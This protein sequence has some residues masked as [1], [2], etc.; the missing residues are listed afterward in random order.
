MSSILGLHVSHDSSACVVVDGKVVSAVQEERLSRVKFDEGFPRRALEW[1]IRDSG[2]ARQDLVVAVAGMKQH[3]ET[4]CWNYLPTDKSWGRASRALGRLAAKVESLAPTGL[5]KGLYFSQDYYG[6]WLRN[7]LDRSGLNAE[8]LFFADHHRCHAASAFYASPFRNA[9]ILTQDGRGDGLS[10]TCYRGSQAG[11][12]NA[13]EQDSGCSLGQLYAGVTAFLGF[14]PLRH[15]G[16]ITGLAAFGSDSE[17]REDL[18]ALFHVGANGAL[19]RKSS[20]SI[21]RELGGIELTAREK[22]ILRV[23][24]AHYKEHV[25]FGIF[26]RH[27]L[28]VKASGMSRED[29][30][31]AIQ[32]ATE[33]VMI[34]SARRSIESYHHGGRANLCLAGGLFANVKLNQR[35]AEM[36]EVDRIFVQ[37]AMGD[38]GLAVG[39]AYLAGQEHGSVPRVAT[40]EVYSG[41][42]FSDSEIEP[43]LATWPSNIEFSRSDHVEREIGELL[44]R[45]VIVG[46]FAGRMEFGPR[47]L[48]ARS[49]LVHPGDPKVNQTINERLRRTEFMP[50]APSVLDRRAADYFIGFEDGQVA[51]DFMTV[52]YDVYP[53]QAPSIAAVVHI[54]GTARPQVV[55]QDLNPSYYSVLEEFESR[56][57]IGC[58]VNTSFNMHEEPIVATPQD[59]LRAFDQGSVDVLAIGSF[60]VRRA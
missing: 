59:A 43:I 13:F 51:A 55:H 38:S 26:F 30:A 4:P 50:F 31:Y 29:V 15:E 18:E 22:M 39:A 7:E 32:C 10:G 54:D 58:I 8:G 14:R 21:A 49:I 23:S 17:L 33:N 34:S 44:A 20:D 24:P 16:K 12:E 41:L 25:R 27:W 42:E 37:P 48:G 53:E 57:G 1:V 19:G 46:R 5:L 3:T 6:T 45:G 56:T 52:T 36:D 11:L 28:A 35:L 40:R 47:A 9:L 60:V 2:V